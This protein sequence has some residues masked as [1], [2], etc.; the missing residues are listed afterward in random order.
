MKKLS[1]REELGLTHVYLLSKPFLWTRT[2]KMCPQDGTFQ[3]A[4]TV[5]CRGPVL[6]EPCPSVDK[7]SD[8]WVSSSQWS[9]IDSSSIFWAHEND[10]GSLLSHESQSWGGGAETGRQI[11][12]WVFHKGNVRH[13]FVVVMLVLLGWGRRRQWHPTPVLLPGKS[14]GQRSLVGCSPWGR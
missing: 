13:L 3:G 6:W 2:G 4:T 1:L 9:F 12:N 8:V 14:H 5:V 7:A 11:Q 10:K